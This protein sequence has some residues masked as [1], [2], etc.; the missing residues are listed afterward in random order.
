MGSSPISSTRR[1]RRNFRWRGRRP[2]HYP[3]HRSVPGMAPTIP[4]PPSSPPEAPRIESVRFGSQDGAGTWRFGVRDEFGA[5]WL[6]VRWFPSA[7]ASTPWSEIQCD[8][9]DGVTVIDTFGSVQASIAPVAA[10][11]ASVGRG[12]D[13][14]P[15]PG[16]ARRCR[17]RAGATTQEN[18]GTTADVTF[19]SPWSEWVAAV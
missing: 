19:W 18:P 1:S 2:E 10:H 3:R 7:S 13:F 12:H 17:A 5:M 15:T 11:W 6:L 8:G 14:L 9:A 16:T 4:A